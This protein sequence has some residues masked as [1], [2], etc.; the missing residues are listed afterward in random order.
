MIG[1]AHVWSQQSDEQFGT[2]ILLFIQKP[3]EHRSLAGFKLF[4]LFIYVVPKTLGN[5][6]VMPIIYE[7]IST[8]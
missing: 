7:L 5:L 4:F 8:R 1:S 2:L 6:R 3:R